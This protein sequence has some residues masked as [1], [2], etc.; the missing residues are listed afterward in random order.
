M[1]DIVDVDDSDIDLLLWMSSIWSERSA[2]LRWRYLKFK[3]F[4]YFQRFHPLILSLRL[5]N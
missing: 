5:W 1:D 4:F 3:Y 2:N